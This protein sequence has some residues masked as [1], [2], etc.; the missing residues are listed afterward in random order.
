VI[1]I[2]INELEVTI[3]WKAVVFGVF[4]VLILTEL[5]IVFRGSLS[6]SAEYLIASFIVGIIVGGSVVDGIVNGV[7]TSLIGGIIALIIMFSTVAMFPD[8]GSV[9]FV[10]LLSIIVMIVM[11]VIGGSLGSVIRML[12]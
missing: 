12:I 8:I 3:H 5:F 11:G 1:T 7:L 6:G 10:I 9:L 4:L 2:L